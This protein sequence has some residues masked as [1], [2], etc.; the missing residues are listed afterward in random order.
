MDKLTVHML[1]LV[2]SPELPGVSPEQRAGNN[3]EPHQVLV[4]THPEL[5]TNHPQLYLEA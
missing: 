3:P 4:Q 1:T 5:V 2:E